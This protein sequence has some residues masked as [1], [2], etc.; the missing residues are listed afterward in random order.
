MAGISD[1]SLTRQLQLRIQFP[2]TIVRSQGPV[3][4]VSTDPRLG[5]TLDLALWSF[6]RN[7]PLFSLESLP[8][9]GL[10]ELYM[11]ANLLSRMNLN[12][13]LEPLLSFRAAPSDQMYRQSRPLAT[14]HSFQ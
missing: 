4:N 6:Y 13:P 12:Q 7:S 3:L 2:T 1:F 11:V 8:P 14:H 5:F 9:S 10:P